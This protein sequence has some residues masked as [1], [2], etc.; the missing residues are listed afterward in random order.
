M[1]SIKQHFILA[2]LISFLFFH[3]AIAQKISNSH[4]DIITTVA[5]SPDGKTLASGSLDRNIILWD[6]TSNQPTKT[7][8]GHK[9]YIYS[10]V[11]TPDGKFLISGSGDKTI[12]FWDVKTGEQ[13]QTLKG[14]EASV[15]ALAISND[16]KVL[17][18]GDTFGTLKLWEVQSGKELHTINGRLMITS[19]AFSSDEKIVA[20]AQSTPFVRLW[21]VETGKELLQ[22]SDNSCIFHSVAISANGKTLAAGCSDTTPYTPSNP[23]K[24]ADQTNIKLWELPSGKEI[25][26]IKG[27]RGFN[28]S[29]VFSKDSQYL[30]SAHTNRKI[31]LWDVSGG[32]IVNVIEQNQTIQ[33]LALSPDGKTLAKAGG[34]FSS[35]KPSLLLFD[36]NKANNFIELVVEKDV[37]QSTEKIGIGD[38]IG[39][40]K[41]GGGGPATTKSE[42]DYSRVFRQ[43]ETSQRARITSNPQPHY[44]EKARMYMIEGVVRIVAVLKADG[45]ITNIRAVSEL[46]F[47]LTDTAIRAASGIKFEPAIK[48]D[49]KV[50]QYVTLEYNFR[51]F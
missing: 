48:D 36:Y 25:K 10:V 16:G 26:T 44:T 29:L 23:F 1:F 12:C 50:S 27:H 31:Y 32:S 39:P 18:S 30:F 15:T 49:R 5:F 28:F 8:S 33:S 13:K 45:Q 47:G 9:S 22:L 38:G 35:G 46:P 37:E 42:T 7:L 2:I 3:S 20:D 6:T 21:S 11:F 4:K 41:T 17:A 24:P 40:G 19:I 34:Y 51:I 14:H 43:S